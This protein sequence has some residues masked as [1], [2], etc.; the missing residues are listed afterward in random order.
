MAPLYGHG[1]ASKTP[2]K[3]VS[4]SRSI[5]CLYRDAKNKAHVTTF[6]FGTH[7]MRCS[8]IVKTGKST[9]NCFC[10]ISFD[11]CSAHDLICTPSQAFYDARKL[12]WV[13][14]IELRS[15]DTLLAAQGVREVTS[16]QFIVQPLQVFALEVEK[17]HTFYA[18]HYQ[19]LTHNMFLPTI[20]CGLGVSFG[21]GAS[22]GGTAGSFFG[23]ITVVGG[24]VIGGITACAITMLTRKR[25]VEYQLSFD[26]DKIGCLIQCNEPETPR[27]EY[28]IEEQNPP[29]LGGNNPAPND[30]NK[31]KSKKDGDTKLQASNK[32]VDDLVGEAT[33]KEQKRRAILYEK[34]GGYKQAEIDYKSLQPDNVRDGSKLKDGSVLIGDLSDGSTAILRK[35]S[36]K[37]PEYPSGAPTLE[38]QKVPDSNHFFKCRYLV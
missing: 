1:L 9:S 14:A 7:S 12:R 38:I 2:I 31:K 21:T 29:P 26:V 34:N 33:F 37:G 32:T 30:E 8:R 3:H 18:G 35:S 4:S 13:S 20:V 24:V 17:T 25:R 15:G 11:T 23:P 16:I 36:S 27:E 19:I 5:A 28:R 6:D 10:S 22:V